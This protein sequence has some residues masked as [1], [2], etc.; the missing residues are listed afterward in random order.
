MLGEDAYRVRQ[1][2]LARAGG[3]ARQTQLRNA[4]GEEGYRVHQRALYQ[5]AVEKHGAAKMQAILAAAHEQRRCWR[6]A[7]PTPAEEVMHWAL[8]QAGFVLHADYTATWEC[9]RHCADPSRWPFTAT[10]VL[11]E[12]RVGPYACDLLLPVR[13][14]VIEVIGGVHTLTAERD[15]IRTETLAAQGLAVVTFTNAQV[16]AGAAD[17]LFNQLLEVPYAA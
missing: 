5:R 10:D 6:L 14:L 15:A 7:N 17:R 9:S 8:I 16:F 4:L 12:A 13:A 3:I 2:A 11:I 1:S